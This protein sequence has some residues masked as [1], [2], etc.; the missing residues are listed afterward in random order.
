MNGKQHLL[1]SGP[2]KP[3]ENG[4]PPAD[5]PRIEILDESVLIREDSPAGTKVQRL[6]AIEFKTSTSNCTKKPIGSQFRVCNRSLS[7][8]QP[9][10]WIVP[11]EQSSKVAP[12]TVV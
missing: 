10:I 2:A 6:K 9:A 1:A 4:T 8:S 11:S 7:A 12:V 3:H 5:F